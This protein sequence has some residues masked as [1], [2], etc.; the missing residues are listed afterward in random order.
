MDVQYTSI[1]PA[2]QCVS[3]LFLLPPGQVGA[4]CKEVEGRPAGQPAGG[5][6]PAQP[7]RLAGQRRALHTHRA[8]P[9]APGERAAAEQ[10]SGKLGHSGDHFV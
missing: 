9:A 6:G 4:G 10:V 3:P 8:E 7:D 5:A 1:N 2:C